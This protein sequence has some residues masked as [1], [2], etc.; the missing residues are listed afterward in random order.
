LTV[1]EAR[2]L[3]VDVVALLAYAREIYRDS[4]YRYKREPVD[5]SNIVSEVFGTRPPQEEDKPPA[6]P[7]LKYPQ[8]GFHINA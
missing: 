4:R 1:E 5:L 2:R 3:G 6:L 7:M 8:P